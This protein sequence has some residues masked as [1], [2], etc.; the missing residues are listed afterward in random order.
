MTVARPYGIALAMSASLA[1]LL[2]SIASCSVAGAYLSVAAGNSA[3][4]HG[5]YEEATVDYLQAAK[6]GVH[7]PW[8]SY[9]LG[10][11]YHA[12]GEPAGATEEWAKAEKDKAPVLRSATSFNEGIL[13]Y[14][15]GN[16]RAAYE[17]FRSVLEIDPAD[18]DAKINLELAY[19]RMTA[20]EH[21][22][23]GPRANE[24]VGIEYNRAAADTLMNLVREKQGSYWV[25]PK[26]Q[27]K[28]PRG[29]D[30]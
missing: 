29:P 26:P 10:N 1:L 18:I 3:Y 20:Q 24:K 15:L 27:G 28:Q 7:L 19:K 8:I 5:H 13:D 14:E 9:D 11:V 12:L 16:Y 22:P 2:A 30:Y 21:P 17:R 6:S 4:E 23:A 25:S